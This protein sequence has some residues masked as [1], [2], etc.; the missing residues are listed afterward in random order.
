MEVLSL[1]L[2]D[3]PLDVLLP[4]WAAIRE[5]P[6]H[7]LHSAAADGL[8]FHLKEKVAASGPQLAQVIEE[9]LTP[10]LR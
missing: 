8:E 9:Y 5:R 4:I 6:G 10:S 3:R 2:Y 1:N 7:P